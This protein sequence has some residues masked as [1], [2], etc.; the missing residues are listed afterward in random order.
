MPDYLYEKTLQ[1]SVDTASANLIGQLE[2]QV[3]AQLPADETPVR[4]AVT[5]SEAGQWTCEIGLLVGP[6]RPESVFRFTPRAREHET[7]FNVV[8]LVPTG[9]GAEIGGHAGDATPAA[10]LLASVCDTLITHPNVLNAS[11][12]IQIPP[13]ALYVEGSVITRLLMGT[14]GLER[15]RGNRLLVVM[16]A[17]QDELFTNAAI[18]SV[19]AA[20]ASYGLQVT[21]IVEIDPG[22]RMVSEY[23]S[24]GAAAGKVEGLGYLWDI[25]DRRAGEFDAVAIT[26]V[27]EVPPHYHRE[28]YERRGQMVNPW[29]GVEAILTHAIS[30]KYMVPAAHSP[31]FESREIAELDVGVVDPR[32]AAEV[33]S[34]TFLQSVLRG[35]QHS[36]R[37][38][39]LTAAPVSGPL[40]TV[41]DIGALVVPSGCLGLPTLA[42]LAQRIP[43]IEVE[44]N[45]TLLRNDLARLAW[46][47]DRFFRV[48]NYLEAAGLLAALR[49]GLAR[50]AVERPLSEVPLRRIAS[51]LNDRSGSAVA[52]R[53]HAGGD[54][55]V[56]SPRV[57][58]T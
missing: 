1:T 57:D 47:P 41:D 53:S 27:V 39:A 21:E 30:S 4:L 48:R 52:Q 43:V 51:S 31:M 54:P 25:L 22:F 24:T 26:S 7:A 45:T 46:S 29:G 35:L 34:I 17:H 50:E 10:T 32:M 44:G 55:R 20:R 37:I 14:V 58:P 33:V 11:D 40:L 18:N 23:T 16:Q 8:M 38:P 42:A 2:G 56:R 49:L 36:P 15:I 12:I 19:N 9:I 3:M 28:Y 6:E 5:E 13:N